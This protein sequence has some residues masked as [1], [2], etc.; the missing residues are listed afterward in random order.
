MLPDEE[1]HRCPCSP[2]MR[3]MVAHTAQEA[4]IE[5]VLPPVC[6]EWSND[7]VM[8]NPFSRCPPVCGGWSALGVVGDVDEQCSPCMRGMVHPSRCPFA[9]YTG[10]VFTGQD[11]MVGQLVLPPVCGGWS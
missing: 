8:G 3:G 5:T 2:C 1:I 7:N 9:L 11:V 4:L 10:M 6:G